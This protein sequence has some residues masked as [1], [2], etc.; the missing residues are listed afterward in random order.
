MLAVITHLHTLLP[1]K[2]AV[3]SED[4]LLNEDL[5]RVVLGN[6][7]K[8]SITPETL[9]LV[10]IHKRIVD[11]GVTVLQADQTRKLAGAVKQAKYAI[12]GDRRRRRREQDQNQEGSRAGGVGELLARD[13]GVQEVSTLSATTCTSLASSRCSR[14]LYSVARCMCLV[15]C[16][17]HVEI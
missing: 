10:G 2:Q 16:A 11:S 3:I 5:Q 9:K 6:P 7:H 17:R 14:Y 13:R 4:L 12:Q 8:P 1:A 15:A